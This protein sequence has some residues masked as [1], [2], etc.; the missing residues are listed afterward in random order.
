MPRTGTVRIFLSSF[1]LQVQV[2][3]EGEGSIWYN[4]CGSEASGRP[5]V[6]LVSCLERISGRRGGAVFCVSLLGMREPLH[7]R[8]EGENQAEDEQRLVQLEASVQC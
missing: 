1:R 5:W 3:L 8:P 7:A 2:R 6:S 4:C